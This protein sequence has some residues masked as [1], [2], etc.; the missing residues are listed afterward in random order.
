MSLSKKT[1]DGIAS[2]LKTIVR[3]K[4]QKYKPE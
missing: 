1:K 3:E 2:L 4:L